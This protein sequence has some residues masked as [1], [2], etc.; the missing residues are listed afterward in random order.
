MKRTALALAKRLDATRLQL[1]DVYGNQMPHVPDDRLAPV[2]LLCR[3]T[4]NFRIV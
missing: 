3:E 4:D 1:I 2:T